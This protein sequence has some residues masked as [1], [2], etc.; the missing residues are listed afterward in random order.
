MGPRPRR[1][2]SPE[3]DQ[4]QVALARPCGGVWIVLYRG[5]ADKIRGLTRRLMCICGGFLRKGCREVI[6]LPSH[7]PVTTL[8]P[9]FAFLPGVSHTTAGECA[10]GALC[11]SGGGVDGG[12]HSPGLEVESGARVGCSSK[13]PCR[14]EGGVISAVPLY[15]HIE[16]RSSTSTVT[17]KPKMK[18]NQNRPIS[19]H[20]TQRQ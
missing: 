3:G 16:P 1:G 6:L 18:A 9:R 19:E 17:V 10:W 11:S 2:R 4:E 13:R 12:E 20:T 5:L 14:G 8:R 7:S 15:D